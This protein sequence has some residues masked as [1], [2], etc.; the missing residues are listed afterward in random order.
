MG[1]SLNGKSKLV[2]YGASAMAGE[3]SKCVQKKGM[4]VC[5]F[6]DRNAADIRQREAVPVYTLEE[7]ECSP[8]AIVII[9]LQNAM[10]HRGIV[11]KLYKKGIERIVFFPM[12]TGGLNAEKAIVLRRIYNQCVRLAFDS[13]IREIPTVSELVQS[14]GKYEPIIDRYEQEITLWCPIELC[15]SISDASRNGIWRNDYTP[16]SRD[17]LRKYTYDKNIYGLQ[18][19]WELFDYLYGEIDECPQYINVYGRQSHIRTNGHDDAELLANR[20]NLLKV[21][22]D[23]ICRENGLSFFQDSPADA[24]VG[25]RGKVI[26]R[27]GWHRSIFLA[28]RGYKWIPVRITAEE[29]QRTFG[30]RGVEKL[31]DW[32]RENKA[33]CLEYPIEHPGFYGYPVLRQDVREIWR[34]ITNEIGR[35]NLNIRDVV[36]L[37]RT[38]GYFSRLFLREGADTAYCLLEEEDVL[39]AMIND[40]FEL[41]DMCYVRSTEELENGLRGCDFVICS[42]IQ[43]AKWGA[44]MKKLC[45]ETNMIVCIYDVLMRNAG[46]VYDLFRGKEIEVA[47]KYVVNGEVNGLL[48][49]Y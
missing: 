14:T 29:Y 17:K 24:V 46:D 38:N 11:E 43:L 4:R 45:A 18:L 6:L 32:L 31:Y 5:A 47:K 48:F 3:W 20:Y 13:E 2:I 15:Y 1:F 40:L 33:E 39:T 28:R 35:K 26:I 7:W 21:Y 49:A 9:L 36:D 8:D 25:E 44:I 27:D 19:Y 41:G 34:G 37:S 23:E 42:K 12:S 16:E 10:Q 30:D 22:E